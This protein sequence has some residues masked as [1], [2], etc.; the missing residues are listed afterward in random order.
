MVNDMYAK[1][2]GRPPFTHVQLQRVHI[3]REVTLHR[4]MV[5]CAF[6]IKSRRL[7]ASQNLEPDSRQKV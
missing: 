4:A 7:L 5:P 6:S 1:E 2:F 3:S